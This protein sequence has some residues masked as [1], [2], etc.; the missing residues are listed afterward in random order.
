MFGRSGLDAE[1]NC[2]FTHVQSSRRL[3]E[4]DAFS[5]WEKL[6]GFT[7]TWGCQCAEDTK[8]IIFQHYLHFVLKDLQ[9]NGCVNS[10]PCDSSIT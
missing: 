5:H 9:V 10:G 7:E 6:L 4:S 1:R 2:A 3:S 8:E